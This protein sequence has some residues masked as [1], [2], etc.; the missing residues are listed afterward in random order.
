MKALCGDLYFEKEI[1]EVQ[2]Y[3]CP[4]NGLPHLLG[5]GHGGIFIVLNGTVKQRLTESML[6]TIYEVEISGVFF[7]DSI[8]SCSVFLETGL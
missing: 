6:T 3:A 4:V 7:G 1:H 8:V 2:F 5:P